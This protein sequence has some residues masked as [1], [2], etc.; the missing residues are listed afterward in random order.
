MRTAF[1]NAVSEKDVADLARSLLAR[2]KDG[3]IAAAQLFLVYSLGK[4]AAMKDPDELDLE[5][6]E[7]MLRRPDVELVWDQMRRPK[8][9]EG[10]KE[11]ILERI[12]ATIAEAD[13]PEDEEPEDDDFDE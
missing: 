7:L 11:R 13:A 4:P 12:R 10:A 8:D 5:E 2:A 9:V 1:L 3:D 6:F